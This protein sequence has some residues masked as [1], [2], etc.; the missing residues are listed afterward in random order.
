MLRAPRGWQADPSNLRRLKPSPKPAR[1]DARFDPSVS[2]RHNTHTIAQQP[3][4]PAG[5]A[6]LSPKSL[7]QEAADP[8][9]MVDMA[10]AL[11]KAVKLFG[12]GD[13]E[14]TRRNNP[15]T[16]EVIEATA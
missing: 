8:S 6:S 5:A 15:D 1:A 4:R 16:D 13:K 11:H 14:E 10:P 7:P 9:D 12:R 3:T 2:P